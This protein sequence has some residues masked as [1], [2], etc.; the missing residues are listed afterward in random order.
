MAALGFRSKSQASHPTPPLAE[1]LLREDDLPEGTVFLRG[2][3][4]NTVKDMAEFVGLLLQKPK[5]VEREMVYFAGGHPD[6]GPLA[7]A[8]GLYRYQTAEQ[9]RAQF[10]Q[11]RQEVRLTP[12]GRSTPIVR[13]S[14]RSFAKVK[15]QILEA[16]DPIGTAYWFIGVY[17]D[18]LIILVTLGPDDSG[19]RQVLETVLPK[20]IERISGVQ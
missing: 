2:E 16:A 7:I 4:P 13:Q 11:L 1:L 14:E 6:D 10:E 12:L 3:E 20:L 18:V 17:E 15:G 5:V 9:A 19:Q 8:H